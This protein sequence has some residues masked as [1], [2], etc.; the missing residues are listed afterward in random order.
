[1]NSNHQYTAHLWDKQVRRGFSGDKWTSASHTIITV[2]NIAKI[3]GSTTF[4]VL[5]R[6]KRKGSSCLRTFHFDTEFN[7]M[8]VKCQVIKSLRFCLAWMKTCIFLD[9]Q[10]SNHVPP[11]KQAEVCKPCCAVHF[12]KHPFLS[13]PPGW[14]LPPW[15]PTSSYILAVTHSILVIMVSIHFS[16]ED[17]TFAQNKHLQILTSILSHESKSNPFS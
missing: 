2:R 9:S 3:W 17:Y 14:L 11:P 8:P 12:I 10:I 4:L 16:L 6:L 7:I 1:M 13:S 15:E 5:K